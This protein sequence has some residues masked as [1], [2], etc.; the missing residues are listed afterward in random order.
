MHMRAACL[1][2]L[3]AALLVTSQVGLP[4][5][6]PFFT[7]SAAK[8]LH[9]ASRP[10]P[11]ARGTCSQR[12]NCLSPLQAAGRALSAS[13]PAAADG[14]PAQQLAAAINTFGNR[15]FQAL[16]APQVGVSA[17]H[18]LHSRAPPPVSAAQRRRACRL[19]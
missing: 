8:P 13:P 12:P 5:Q 16:P 1:G 14:S 2:W 15:L 10:C 19:S 7:M 11:R 17:A 9:L 6:Q 4:C 18:C 3:L